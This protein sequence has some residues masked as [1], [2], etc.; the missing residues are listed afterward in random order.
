MLPVVARR[1]QTTS[2]HIA[3][4]IRGQLRS[5]RHAQWVDLAAICRLVS[6][7]QLAAA[8]SWRLHP[9]Y[10]QLPALQALYQLQ[11]WLDDLDAAWGITGSAG[12]E[13]ASGWPALGPRSDLD[14]LLR[15]PHPPSTTALRQLLWRTQKLGCR[16]DI[17][18]E[19]PAGGIALQE[20]LR[21]GKVMVKTGSGPRLLRMPWEMEPAR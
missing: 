18:L 21:G 14:L 7:E 11:P 20:W 15:T 8:H 9:H 4:G 3:V 5:Q 6:P 19:T 13:L 12:F 1:E 2:Q 17:Q 10:R 16:V